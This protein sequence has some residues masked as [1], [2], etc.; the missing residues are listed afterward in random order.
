LFTTNEHPPAIQMDI[1]TER[2]LSATSSPQAG[3]NMKSSGMSLFFK[4]S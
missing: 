2:A 4:F 1:S 3:V